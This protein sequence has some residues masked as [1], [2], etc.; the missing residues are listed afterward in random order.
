[1]DGQQPSVERV[2]VRQ[3]PGCQNTSVLH[4]GPRYPH[5]QQVE[6]KQDCLNFLNLTIKESEITSKFSVRVN[7]LTQPIRPM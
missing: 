1:M 2:R 3:H 5:V 7:R 6:V 4:L